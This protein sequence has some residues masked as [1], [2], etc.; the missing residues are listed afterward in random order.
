MKSAAPIAA[1]ALAAALATPLA[2]ASPGSLCAGV[3]EDNRAIE[4]QFPH[5]LKL[6]YAEPGG[7]YLGDIET[8]IK[9]GGETLVS[10]RCIGPWLLVDLPA[11]TYDVTADYQGQVKTFSVSVPSDG[12]EVEKTVTF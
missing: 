11:G 10:E 1:A 8:T 2:A 7:A 4:E 5:T 12:R 6:V 9:A 3:G